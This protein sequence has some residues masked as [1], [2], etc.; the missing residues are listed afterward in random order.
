MI[1]KSDVLENFIA[2]NIRL[3]IWTFGG[4]F[5]P[6]NLSL[7]VFTADTSTKELNQEHRPDHK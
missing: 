7:A 2:F 5:I 6:L 3:L 4:M 1:F